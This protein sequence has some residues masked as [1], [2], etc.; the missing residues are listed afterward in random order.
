MLAFFNAQQRCYVCSML[1]L[2]YY[3]CQMDYHNNWI[4]R[5]YFE[6]VASIKKKSR[7][8]FGKKKYLSCSTNGT[9]KS[10]IKGKVNNAKKV[11]K[12]KS[13]V[14]AV[15]KYTPVYFK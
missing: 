11:D 2:L 12:T 5:D 10:I 14:D 1:I 9:I 15:S 13:A 8:W 4:G 3:D 7:K 6:S